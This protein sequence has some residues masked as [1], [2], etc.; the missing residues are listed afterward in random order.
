MTY[1]TVIVDFLKVGFHERLVVW[2]N[3]CQIVLL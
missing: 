2:F 1:L 3:E